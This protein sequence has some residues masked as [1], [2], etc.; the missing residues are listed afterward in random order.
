MQGDED[1]SVAGAD[2]ESDASASQGLLPELEKTLS[3]IHDGVETWMQV[4][5]ASRYVRDL[6]LRNPDWLGCLI[7]DGLL[8]RD[9]QGTELSSA[10]NQCLQEVTQE[11]QMMAKLRQFRHQHLLRIAWR[12]ISGQTSVAQT[13]REL[14]WLAEACI[15]ISLQWLH[16]LLQSRFGQP[17][18]RESGQSQSLIVLGMGKLGGQDLNFSSDIDLIFTYPEQGMTQ[19]GERSLSNEEYFIRLGQKLIQTLDR[20]TEDGFVYRVD[21][22]LRPFGQQGRL[23]LSFDAMEHYYQ[24]HGRTWERYAL[25]KARPV[26]GDI[27]SGQQLLQRLRP[28]IYRRY[29]DFNMLDD[30]YRLKQ[31]I[32]DKA[33]GEQE[34]NDLKLGPGGIR[35]VEF[36]VQSWQLVYGGRYPDLQTSRIMEAM[37]AAI[38]HHLVIPE[39]AET[40]QSAYY[41]LRQAENRLQQYQDRQIHHLPDD[42]SGR[43]RIAVSMGYNSLEVFESQLDRHRAEVSRQ[44][45]STFG[46]NDVQP[47]DES[48]KNRYVRFWSLIETADINTDT[49]LDDELAAF[50][51]VQPR[52]QEFF[53]KNRPLLP[54]AARRALRQ[55]MPVMLEMVLELDENQEEVLKRFLTMLQA[56]SGRTNYLVLLA[57]NPHIL[58]FVLR[59]CSMSQWLS[60]QMARFPLLLDSLIDHR[61]WLHD[62]DQRHLPE[63]L[64]RILD[65]R[66]D[67]EDWMEGLRQFKLQQV[68]QIACQSIFSDLTAMQTANRLTAV[69]ETILNEILARLWQELLDRSK[70]EGPGIDQSGLALIGYGKLGGREMGYTSDLDLIVLYDPGRF[71]LEQSEGIRLVRR[72]MHVLSAY[73]PSGVLYEMDARLRPEGNSGLL[74][75]SMQAFV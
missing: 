75:T 36:V 40:L 57:Q 64:S 38:R 30:L 51:V 27:D 2:A 10:L 63:E 7:D 14:S 47:V 50:S 56:I 12:D 70:R 6:V 11:E 69:A 20:V 35:E 15:D 65:G 8:D 53:L 3:R 21:M 71:K 45:E 60:R 67:M 13:L 33:K 49:T 24:T 43:L 72:M 32:S 58:D 46:G 26:A 44:F 66:D 23:A 74:V 48:S 4:S 61:Q 18:G 42:K 62:H 25:I 1:R 28:F 68:F 37:Q 22:R 55:L 9:L 16:K 17:I 59:C 34:C 54:E 41:F 73:T 19:G 52:L 31:A 39:D 5:R 29:L